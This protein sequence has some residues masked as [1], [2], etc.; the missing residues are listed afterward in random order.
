MLLDDDEWGQWSDRE[1]ARQCGVSNK[2]VGDVRASICFPNT[3]SPADT[4]AQPA[5][6][7]TCTVTRNGPPTSRRSRP[8]RPRCQ[9]HRTQ[10]HRRRPPGSFRGYVS[11]FDGA[12]MR[13]SNSNKPI[14]WSIQASSSRRNRRAHA[15]DS[16]K[17]G[18]RSNAQD[19]VFREVRLAH[20]RK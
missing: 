3:D 17:H 8:S 18:A 16:R 13:S 19:S 6:P 14:M 15:P 11:Y 12:G 4:P 5:A 9:N 2:F 7:A 10:P 1:I 20:A